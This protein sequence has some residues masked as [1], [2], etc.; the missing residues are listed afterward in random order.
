MWW[1]N[2]L[3]DNR[4]SISHIL[5][6]DPII[7]GSILLIDNIVA[8]KREKSEP[9]L[10]LKRNE[11]TKLID[12]FGLS[13]DTDLSRVRKLN[14][15]FIH[16]GSIPITSYV[17]TLTERQHL[18]KNINL[19]PPK[20]RL[21]QLTKNIAAKIEPHIYSTLRDLRVIFDKCLLYRSLILSGV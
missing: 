12:S 1:Y 16:I 10:I 3:G 14:V 20:L 17:N 13:I 18:D 7:T 4:V 19:E 5:W 15:Y 2:I 21:Y 8:M 6:I 11:W 9:I